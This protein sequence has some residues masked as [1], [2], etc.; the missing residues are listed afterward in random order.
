MLSIECADFQALKKEA[1]ACQTACNH[2]HRL[3]VLAGLTPNEVAA[4]GTLRLLQPS[5][6]RHQAGSLPQNKGFVSFVRL[7]RKS[8]RIIRFAVSDETIL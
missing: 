8:G 4:Q 3:T 1:Q 6:Q 5:Y 2:A 7:I